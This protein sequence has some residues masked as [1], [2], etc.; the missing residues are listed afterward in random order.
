MRHALGRGTIL[1]A[2]LLAPVAALGVSTADPPPAPPAARVGHLQVWNHLGSGRQLAHGD[3]GEAVAQVGD[4]SHPAAVRGRGAASLG[5]ESYLAVSQAGFFGGDR[6]Q[7]TVEVF[8]QK[9]MP[10]S[11][12]FETPL[13]AVFGV[14]PYQGQW[15]PIDA[16]WSDGFTGYGGLQFEILDATG[17]LHTAND[18]GWDSVAVGRWVHVMFVWDLDGIRGSSDRLRIYRDG[19]LV[20]SNSDRIGSIARATEPVK[21]LAT[22]AYER[23]GR[24]ALVGDELVV[25]SVP[26]LP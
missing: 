8:L 23:L 4:V 15:G 18:L 11:V 19:A 12:P 24:P 16:Y 5:D 26:R 9:R 25:W 14:Q 20:A 17:T 21:V 22:H 7:G 13:P 1:L 3:A 2:A 6:T 10:V